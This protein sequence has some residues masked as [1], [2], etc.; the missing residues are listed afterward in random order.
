MRAASP[1]IGTETRAEAL[2]GAAGAN[3]P[4]MGR[5]RPLSFLMKDTHRFDLSEVAYS[6]FDKKRNIRIPEKPSDL[7]AEETA[8]HL[9]DGYLF[10]DE[11]DRSYRFGIG[12]NPKTEMSY[13]YAVAELIGQ[14]YGYKPPVRRARIE[15]MSLAIGTFKHKVLALPIGTRTG[16]EDLP[17]I[18]WV[19]T[20]ERFI[21]AF[22]RGL[23]DTEG[24]VKKISRTIGVVVKQRNKK[25]IEFYAQCLA[26]LGFRPRMYVWNERNKP[27]YVSTLLGKEVVEQFIQLVKPRNPSKH[28]PF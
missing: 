14:L 13:A 5:G 21:T 10:Y 4:Q 15:I 20:D 24:S 19:L 27:I 6:K 17:R 2:R 9:G 22:V 7:L 12:L 16:G 25:I 1:E 23:V 18:E 3:T 26:A 28:P 8:I 11:K